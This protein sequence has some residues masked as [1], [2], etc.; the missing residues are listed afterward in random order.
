[1]NSVILRTA[2]SGLLP[3]LLLASVM[4]LLRGHNEPGGGFVGGL[5]AAA[6]FLL[7]MLAYGPGR[8]RRLLPLPP[9]AITAAGLGAAL[10]S[11]LFAPTLGEPL[12]AALWSDFEPVPGVKFGTPLLFDVGV[13][14]TV[15]GSVLWMIFSIAAWPRSGVEGAGP[16]SAFDAGAAGPAGPDS[17]GDSGGGSR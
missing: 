2:T 6:A 11:G 8:A 4:I 9:E 1:M 15:A 10:L 7:H 12:F 17:G 14:L 3:L 13:Y 5:T 16:A